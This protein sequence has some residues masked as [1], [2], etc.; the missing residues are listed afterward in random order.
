MLYEKNKEKA[1]KIWLNGGS[2]SLNPD[3]FQAF[4]IYT[5]L[6]EPTESDIKIA[7]LTPL[8]AAALESKG[9]KIDY[10]NR[11]EVITAKKALDF[12]LK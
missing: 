11:Q 8:L 2:E 12:F 6:S 1:F 7:K 10:T 4:L 9:I 5:G 3:F